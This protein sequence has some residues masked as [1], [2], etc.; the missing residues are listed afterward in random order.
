MQASSKQEA[1]SLLKAD[2]AYIIALKPRQNLLHMAFGGRSRFTDKQRIIFFQQLAVILKSGIPLLQ[3]I[4]ILQRRLEQELVPVCS[5]LQAELRAG[6]TL[7]AAMAKERDFFPELAVILTSAGENSGELQR[8]LAAAAAY[9]AGQHALRSFVIQSAAYP[10]FL[11]AA[12]AVVGIFFLVYVLPELGGIYTSM[13]A[14][15]DALL[16]AAITVNRLLAEYYPVFMILLVGCFLIIW[17]RQN[18]ICGWLKHLPLLQDIHGMVLEI[19]FCRLL[20]LLLGSGLNITDAVAQAGRIYTDAGKKGSVFLFHRQLLRGVEIG[21]AA[22]RIPRLFSPLTAE[23]LHIGSATGCLPQMLEEAAA[24]L[25]QDLQ[26]KLARFKEFFAPVL[27]LAA[28]LITA[29]V[30]CSVMGPLFDLFTA[31]PEYE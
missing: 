18:L 25:E 28:A 10:L 23:Y 1:A 7:H 30:L 19:R 3:G 15:P 20:A 11:L 9:Y 13:Q 16:E 5:K 6:S 2:Y 8:V 4:E 24:I 14:K 12:A 31:L 21:T 22:D 17:Q 26:A 27:L 29:L